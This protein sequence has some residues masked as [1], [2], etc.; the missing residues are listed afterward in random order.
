MKNL[1]L[2]LIMISMSNKINAQQL[3]KWFPKGGQYYNSELIHNNDS[4]KYMFLYNDNGN[5]SITTI[6]KPNTPNNSA[7]SDRNLTILSYIEESGNL[8]GK[9]TID[10]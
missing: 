7:Q 1:V 10:G 8:I 3:D 6:D 5:L 2:L 9:C 4:Y